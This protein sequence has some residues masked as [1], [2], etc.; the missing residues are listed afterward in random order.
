MGY[1]E[2]AHLRSKPFIVHAGRAV[3]QVLG[4][5]FVVR[6]YP[7]AE[8]IE[9]SVAEGLVSVRAETTPPSRALSVAP[10][11][12]GTLGPEGPA[13][14]VA[15]EDPEASLGWMNGRT[16]IKDL[17]L[18]EA[19]DELERRYDVELAV[20]DARLA[21]RRIT[22]EVGPGSL[23]ETLDLI[24]LALSARYVQAGDTLLFLPDQ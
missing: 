5:R 1:F 24:A 2:V 9:V 22:T 13:R 8:R 21:A 11:Q 16:V 14:I 15:S 7:G 19:L 10:G 23:R 3:T 12:V 18:Q 6:S 4:T 17:P 20:R